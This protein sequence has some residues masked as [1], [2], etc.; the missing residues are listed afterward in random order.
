MG[1]SLK[2]V[3]YSYRGKYQTVRA[4]NDVSYDC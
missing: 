3:S 1:I 4:V 2:N